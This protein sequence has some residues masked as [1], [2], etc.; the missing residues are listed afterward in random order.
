VFAK[1]GVNHS[2]RKDQIEE[3]LTE[4]ESTTMAIRGIE[5][6]MSRVEG[7]VETVE[8]RRSYFAMQTEE[9]TDLIDKMTSSMNESSDTFLSYFTETLDHF[10]DLIELLEETVHDLQL[11][12]APKELQK[13]LGPLL[14]PSVVLVL[15]ITASNVIFGFLVANDLD[16][17]EKLS[18]ESV[19]GKSTSEDG[20]NVL[21]LFAIFHVVLI[22]LALI[23]L[24]LE[25]CRRIYLDRKNRKKVKKTEDVEVLE[26]DDQLEADCDEQEVAD[27]YARDTEPNYI[28]TGDSTGK[29]TNR[30]DASVFSPKLQPVGDDATVSLDGGS[31]SRFSFSSPRILVNG[32]E[33]PPSSPKTPRRKESLESEMG[34]EVVTK[35][36]SANSP[37]PSTNK[38]KATSH[39]P[40]LSK[41]NNTPK[42][43]ISTALRAM[44]KQATQFIG[45]QRNS[46]PEGDRGS[47]IS[48]PSRTLQRARTR[49]VGSNDTLTEI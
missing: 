16:L 11:M 6:K 33:A 18:M 1:M 35:K 46:S 2:M 36:S 22:S 28:D 4:F 20:F 10:A 8:E 47:A 32:D 19:F 49:R 9:A 38:S 27:E 26:E 21:Y 13:E 48:Y 39:S 34:N 15:I 45:T 12:N 7:Y 31:S 40:P 42:A 29:G 24:F 5:A 25:L 17:T 23:Y 30:N 43:H 37:S 41:T 14:V 3:V 44:G